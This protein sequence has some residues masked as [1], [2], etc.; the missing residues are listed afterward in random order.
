VTEIGRHDVDIARLRRLGELLD[1]AVRVPG[2]RF[3]VGLDALIG[4][5]P[6]IGD[7]LGA[8][9]SG[10][11]V[12]QAARLGVSRATL[13]RMLLNVGVDTV[14]GAIPAVGDIFDFAWKANTRNLALLNAHLERPT[15]VR[16]SSR[17]VLVAIGVAIALIIAGLVLLAAM[18]LKAMVK[19]L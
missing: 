15:A 18:L 14:T 13:A 5:I 11:I 10:Y 1:T 7:A 2:T 8:A 19:Y 12:I 17:R 9:L 16:S 6:G 3:G 4:L